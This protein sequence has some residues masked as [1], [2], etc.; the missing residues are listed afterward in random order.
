MRLKE[1][2]PFMKAYVY[3]RQQC[4]DDYQKNQKIPGR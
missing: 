3:M 2:I 4:D 1:L